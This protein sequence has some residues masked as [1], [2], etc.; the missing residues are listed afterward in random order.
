MSGAREV[1]D[2]IRSGDDRGLRLLLQADPS[3][4]GARTENGISALMTALYHRRRDM[5]DELLSRGL[6][7]DIFEAV[8]LGEREITAELL[9]EDGSRVH[10]FSPDGYTPLHLACFF[11]HEK[12]VARLIER[13]A[14]VDAVARNSMRVRPLHSAA[15]GSS[16]R[17][18]LLLLDAGADPN[19]RQAG[20]WTALHSAA[21]SG[22]SAIARVLVERGADLQA[23]NDEGLT[24]I[25]VA[26][27][28]GHDSVL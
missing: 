19:A 20:G 21:Q 9:R 3:L 28:A 16:R 1:L 23:R 15:A 7:L 17:S 11:D 4:A 12:M 18:V 5:A 10:S 2:A 8:S 24:P 26:H 22:N 27:A 13:G 25:D 6:T 14:D